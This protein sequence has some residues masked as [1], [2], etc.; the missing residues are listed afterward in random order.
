MTKQDERKCKAVAFAIV[1]L[2]EYLEDLAWL[3]EN[4]ICL[5]GSYMNVAKKMFDEPSQE[6]ISFIDDIINESIM[7]VVS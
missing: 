2:A 1:V 4:S 7:E 5:H 3:K 6:V